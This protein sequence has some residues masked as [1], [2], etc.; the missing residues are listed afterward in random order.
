MI[1]S[2]GRWLAALAAAAVVAAC[3]GGIVAGVGSGGSGF[4]LAAGTVSGF[5]SII[6]DGA[7]WDVR[8]ARV[9]TIV[10]PGEPPVLTAAKLGQRVAID[11]RNAG[12]ASTVR[13]EASAVGHVSAVDAAGTPPAFLVAGQTVRINTDTAAGP[14]TVFAGYSSIADVRAG[15][16]VEVHGA[17]RF[18]PALNGYL[19]Q[20][21]RVE[22]LATLPAGRVRV[23]GI[24]EALSGGALRI[25]GLA[26]TTTSATVIAPAARPLAD[27][28]R[29]IA[30]GREPLGPDPT[31]AA[32][33]VRMADTPTGAA[34]G[35]I[36]G[37]VSRFNA[38]RL[39]FEVDG[40]AVDA[41]AA[42]VVPASQSLA[43]GV[44][45]I[46]DGSFRAD[47]ALAASQVHIRRLAPGDTAVQ[48]KGMITRFSS[49]A[50]F[51]VRGVTV[52]ASGATFNGCANTPL[53]QGLYVEVGGNI[54]GAAVKANS[55]TCDATPPADATL[56]LDGVATGVDVNARTFTLALAGNA[57]RSVGWTDTT[58]FVDVTPA[59]LAGRAVEV[60]GFI[61]QG[62]LVATAIRPQ[63]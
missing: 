32:D 29:V 39:A 24:V 50:D 14:V 7:P 52:D 49:A 15:D 35:Q 59:T 27:G 63:P 55:V 46:V 9:E 6:V 22:K 54:A 26:I 13:I 1:V 28:E 48:L 8:D 12:V 62:V 23:A 41:R 21:T 10:D 44:Y 30:W 53:A 34:A 57:T 25:G 56:T 20:A 4:G 11:F 36:A 19:I 38:G 47:G 43:D 45:V 42:L 40:I 58:V 37:L 2:T 61:R 60:D 33:F 31:L 3:G 18:D 5:G 51:V 17:S 16:A